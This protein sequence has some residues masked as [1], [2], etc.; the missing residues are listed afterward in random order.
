MKRATAVDMNMDTFM[1]NGVKDNINYINL[2]VPPTI[3]I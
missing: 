1:E 2:I 3:V